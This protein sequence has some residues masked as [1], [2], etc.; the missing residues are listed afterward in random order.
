MKPLL[1]PV[2]ATMLLVG[3][4]M[5]RAHHSDAA[6]YRVADSIEIS[7]TLSQ[8]QIRNPHSFIFVDLSDPKGSEVRWAGEWRA[9]TQLEREGIN[10]NT[11]KVG[12]KVI[13]RGAPSRN[14]RDTKMLVRSVTRVSD[15]KVFGVAA[16]GDGQ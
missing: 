1:L 5:T 2:I 9:A 4:V 3:T 14:P 12:E 7:G 11:L 8:I 15:G 16:G 13:L 6:T 10:A